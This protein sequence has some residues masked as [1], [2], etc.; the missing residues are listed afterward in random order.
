M[1]SKPSGS[2]VPD[3]DLPPYVA[4]GQACPRCG[5]L[6]CPDYTCGCPES[7]ENEGGAAPSDDQK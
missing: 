1:H 5:E 7:W 3:K 4:K 2:P 6:V